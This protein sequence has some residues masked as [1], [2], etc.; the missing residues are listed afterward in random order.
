M[1]IS[2]EQLLG[3]HALIELNDYIGRPTNACKM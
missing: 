3:Y 2:K 1:A